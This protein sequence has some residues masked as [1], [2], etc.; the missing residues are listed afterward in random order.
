VSPI[1][2]FVE[3]VA[4]P[5][6]FVPG[7]SHHVWH[8][9]NNRCDIFR[10][11]GDRIVFLVLLGLAAQRSDVQIHGYALMDTHYH[12]LV[13]A[14]DEQ[15]LPQMMQRLG[16]AYVGHFNQRHSRS[17]TLWEGR[18]RASL[19]RDERR[20]LTCL[21]Y[22]EMNPVEAGMVQT[23]DAYGWS[24]YRHHALGD[25]DLLLSPHPLLQVRGASAMQR[26]QD[27]RA[28]CG[29]GTSPADRELILNALRRNGSLQEP[30]AI[31]TD[32]IVEDATPVTPTS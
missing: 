18:Y 30:G 27:W 28:F 20:W 9:G 13:T 2:E 21:R 24:S 23:P 5:R 1:L 17:G 29:Q 26:Q 4:P 25:P 16:R 6:L 19:I 12:A 15:A 10:D 8:R 22:I 7:L 31:L 3:C 32:G 14:P 11:D